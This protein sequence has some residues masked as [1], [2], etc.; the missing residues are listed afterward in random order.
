MEIIA[1]QPEIRGDMMDALIILSVC[2]I[3][4]CI[5]IVRST[6]TN[7]IGDNT[8]LPDK[9][10]YTDYIIFKEFTKDDEK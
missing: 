5:C 9:H 8:H 1:I 3:A 10:D 2:I 4:I 6:S 7:Q